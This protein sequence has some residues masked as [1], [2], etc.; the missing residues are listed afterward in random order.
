MV[1]GRAVPSPFWRKALP[2][3]ENSLEEYSLVA[4]N[5]PHPPTPLLN[6]IFLMGGLPDQADVIT[7]A[8]SET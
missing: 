5:F 1:V 2:C 4:F 8:A 3:P 7:S 6:C